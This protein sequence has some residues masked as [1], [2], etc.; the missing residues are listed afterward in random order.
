MHLN[1]LLEGTFN[2]NRKKFRKFTVTS[3][4]MAKY[5]HSAKDWKK[6]LHIRPNMEQTRKVLV[7]DPSAM[8]GV[9]LL[10]QD[11]TYHTQAIV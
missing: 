7:E 2:G 1:L 3:Q 6:V 4:A 10:H 5:K 8:T 11:I 9:L